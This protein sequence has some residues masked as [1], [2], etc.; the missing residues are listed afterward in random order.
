MIREIH[1]HGALGRD[2]GRSVVK[3]SVASPA[4]AVRA[5]CVMVPGA[6][7]RLERGAYMIAREGSKL[8]R[9]VDAPELHFGFTDDERA[10]HIIPRAAGAKSGGGIAKIVLGVILI[11]A[12]FFVPGAGLLGAQVITGSMVAGLGVSLALGGIAAVLA[13]KTKS[14]ANYTQADQE[15]STMFGDAENT[16]APG[17]A[18]PVVIGVCEVGSVVV[19]ASIH[20]EDRA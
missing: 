4:E 7:E 18:V 8:A 6:R 15:K 12:S 2:L 5:L 1:L 19:S 10:L 20:T 14:A 17:A 16:V 3:F 13:P 11:A 9:G